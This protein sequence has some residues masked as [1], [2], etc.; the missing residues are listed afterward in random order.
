MELVHLLVRVNQ[1][2]N[3]VKDT[4]T[5]M[6]FRVVLLCLSPPVVCTSR[7][8][9]NLL[10]LCGNISPNLGPSKVKYLCGKCSKTV[11]ARQR[12]IECSR[13]K[14]WHHAACVSLSVAECDA[15]SDD[16]ECPWYCSS[17]V[18]AINNNNSQFTDT[19]LTSVKYEDNSLT[20]ITSAVSTMRS[21][22]CW[23]FNARSVVNSKT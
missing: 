2:F 19:S 1:D 8:S 21:L 7:T 17:C 12:G 9:C 13:C 10:Q 5:S 18:V 11:T 20:S 15:L 14:I 22:T 16:V 23:C 4:N 3:A 6:D